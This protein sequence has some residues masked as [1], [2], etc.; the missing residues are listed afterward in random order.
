MKKNLKSL[1]LVLLGLVLTP[2]MQVHATNYKAQFND[3]YQWIPNTYVNMKQGTRT[4]YQQMAVIARTSDNQFIYCIEP[5]TPL[6]EF[7]DYTGTD[8]N[9]AYVANMSQ[10]QWKRIQLLAFYGYGYSDSEVNHSDLKWYAITQ[11]MIWQTVPHGWDIYFTDSLKGNR[12]TRYENEMAEMERLVANHYKTPEF[13]NSNFETIIGSTLKITDTNSVLSK[14]QASS[15][16]KVSLS[17]SGNDLYITA[18]EVGETT[19]NLI[20]KDVKYSHPTIVYVRPDSQDLVQVGSYDPLQRNINIK[21]IGGKVAINKVDRDTGKNIP[22][23]DATLKGAVYSV[24]RED[25][26]LITK[27]TTDENG[28]AISGYL[29]SLGKFYLRE[30]TPSKGYELDKNTYEFNIS[31]DNLEPL[32]PVQEKVI[33]RN[34]NFFKVYANDKTGMLVGEPNVTFDIYLKSSGEKYKT[35]TTDSKGYATVK[36]PYGVYIIKQVTATTDYEKV[37]DFEITINENTDEPLYKLISNAPITAKLKVIKID[38][39]TG[40]I[41][42][43]ANIKFKIFNIDTEEYVCQRI[44][45]PTVKDVC[46]FETDENGILI[47]PYPLMPGNYRLE[48]V[49]QR[50]DGYLWNKE[51]VEFHI[52]ENSELIKDDELGVLFEVRFANKEV[53]G[54]V[55]ID[56]IGEKFVIDNGKYTYDKINLANVKIG[57]Y[58]KEDIYSANG[59]LIYKKGELVKEGFTNKAGKLVF[60]NLYLGKYFIKEI[61]TDNNHVLDDKEYELELKYK[62]QYTDNISYDIFLKNYYK[63]GKLEFTKKDLVNGDTIPNTIIEIYNDK[64][65]LVGTYKTDKGGKVSID[66]LAVGKYYIVEKEATTGYI[67]TTEKVYFEIKENGE[68][69]KAEMKNKPVMGSIEIT[70]VDISTGEVLPNTLIEVYNEKDELV[71]S[72]RTDENG[73]I[74]IDNLRYGKYYF[75]EKEA[76]KGYKINEEKMWFEILEDGQIIKSQLAD[77]KNIVEVPNTLKNDYIP[78]VTF[79][80]SMIGLGAIIYGTY[81]KK[82]TKK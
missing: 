72:G 64:D 80:I 12:I 55:T 17:K 54:S 36:L 76:P 7:T 8:V 57:L 34:V 14:W 74:K 4:K 71:F 28:Y 56:K 70:K 35:I 65:E 59:K 58:A 22:Q 6:E 50:I 61:S 53:K 25:G 82:K 37:K 10:E 40:D 13:G 20:K 18:N 81:K 44:T 16:S 66:D 63:K 9:Q 19:I 15:N 41:I 79:G 68:I 69:V 42:A 49:D 33:E 39:D 46:E 47:T 29:P 45:Y 51:S 67:I 73:K 21:I 60:D 26:T 23:G 2:A 75:V 62:G 32:I 48:E 11:F 24:Y 78:Y 30:I 27:I 1:F 52:G 38:K 31:K 43:R 3:K 77:E 5:G